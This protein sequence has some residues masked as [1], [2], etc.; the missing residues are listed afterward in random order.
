MSCNIASGEVHKRATAT[1]AHIENNEPNAALLVV[2]NLLRCVLNCR[3]TKHP[4][5]KLSNYRLI[6]AYLLLRVNLDKIMHS[7]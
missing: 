4:N 2:M 7:C 1:S 5:S 3:V 6:T